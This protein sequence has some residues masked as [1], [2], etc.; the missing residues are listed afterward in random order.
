MAFTVNTNILDLL[1]TLF[2]YTSIDKYKIGTRLSTISSVTIHA[3][4]AMTTAA[5]LLQ[6]AEAGQGCL[7]EPSV[8]WA[9]RLWPAP[10]PVCHTRYTFSLAFLMS[11]PIYMISLDFA[12]FV[13]KAR[14]RTPEKIIM[15]P[16]T[17]TTSVGSNGRR[18]YVGRSLTMDLNQQI[19]AHFSTNSI[20][21][22]P[23]SRRSSTTSNSAS[24]FTTHTKLSTL[25]A[26]YK[27][28]SK[29]LCA[30]D[31]WW[32]KIDL[33]FFLGCIIAG[34][35]SLTYGSDTYGTDTGAEQ[36]DWLQLRKSSDDS[37][38]ERFF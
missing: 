26:A 32:L 27:V 5:A 12:Q 10:L 37:R 16:T 18:R 29:S 20:G 6:S 22:T 9:H 38:T 17:S 36:N 2:W 4:A 33:F 13:S 35:D 23:T 30:H 8:R 34:R 7:T 11:P 21:T 15:T 3:V 19:N 28:F 1:L 31:D 14:G 25:T 24:S